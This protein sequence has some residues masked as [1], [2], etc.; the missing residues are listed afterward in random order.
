MLPLI[1]DNFIL[2]IKYCS[3]QQA[4]QVEGVA[5]PKE[6]DLRHP[7]SEQVDTILGT[8]IQNSSGVHALQRQLLG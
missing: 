8:P 1:T 2:F 3:L 7:P 6:T 4:E 5:P